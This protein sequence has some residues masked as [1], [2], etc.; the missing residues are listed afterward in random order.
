MKKQFL[1]HSILLISASC[2]LVYGLVQPPV[3]NPADG[4]AY[5]NFPLTITCPTPG[6]VIRYTLNGVEPTLYD[7]PITSGS[8]VVINRNWIVKAKA[9]LAQESSATTTG[10]FSITGDVSAGGGHTLALE[11]QGRVWA[12]GLQTNG[13]LG[14]NSVANA[15][16]TSPVASLYSAT[17]VVGDASMVAA[18]ASHSVFLK[19]GGTVWSC[20][21]NS[22]GALGNNSTTS[23]G[24]AV[25]VRKSTVATDFLTGM[26]AVAAGDGFSSALSSSGEVYTWGSKSSGRLGD[27]ATSGSR[28]YAGKVLQGPS[29]STP[30][31]GIAT[32]ANA[33]G[34]AMAISPATH[35]VWV[36]GNNSNGQLGQG[37]TSNLSRAMKMKLNAT[38]ELTDIVDVAGG[39]NHT[40]ILRWK[41]GDPALQGRVFCCGQQQYGRLGNNQ[42]ATA[43]VTYPVQV[44]K[45]GATPLD[46][47]VSIAAGSGHTLALDGNGNVWAWGYNLYGALGDNTTTSRGTASKVLNPTGTGPLTNI[48]RISASGSTTTGHS[49]AIAADGTVYA[50]GYNSNGQLGNGSA[51]TAA[52]RLPSPVVGGLDLLPNPPD[53]SVGVNVTQNPAPGAVTITATVSDVDGPDNVQSVEFYDQ[54]VLVATR[55]SVPWTVSLSGIPAG[56]H[57]VYAI[58]TDAQGYSGMSQPVAFGIEADNDHD[59]LSDAWEI[60][61]FGNIISQ[62]AASDADGDKV[63][64]AIEK[65][66]ATNPLAAADT[67]GDG[68]PDDW[69]KYHF[70]NITS[71]SGVGDVDGDKINSSA[72]WIK[73]TNP[74]RNLNSDNDGLPDDWE[75][76]WFGDLA[77]QSGNSEA[78]ADHVI[79]AQE[80]T[81]NTN[82][83][84]AADGDVDGLPDDWELYWFDDST[85][86]S[87]SS[88]A[89]GDLVSNRHEWL[90]GTNP[91]NAVDRD[92]D[93]LPDD[94]ERHWF[95]DITSNSGNSDVDEDSVSNL[96][97]FQAGT[98][99]APLLE[100][101]NANGVPDNQE[102]NDGDGMA[103]SWEQML[104]DSSGGL[105]EL[106][107]QNILPGDDFDNDGLANWIEYQWGF[108]AYQA[109]SDGDGYDD[110][111]A[112]AQ[113]L[114]L[115]LD[116]AGGGVAEDQSFEQSV[117]V[118]SGTLAWQTNGGIDGGALMFH[119]GADVVEIPFDVL[120]G[121]TALTVSLWFK[122]SNP[123]TSQT[124]LSSTSAARSPEFA[125]GIENGSSIRVHTGGGQSVAWSFGRSLVD[126]RWHHLVVTRDSALGRVAL[127]IDGLAF[128]FPQSL[129][130]GALDLEKISLGQRHQS[131]SSF[132][133]NQAFIGLL[134]EIRIFSGILDTKDV[135][136]LFL[137][138]DLDQDGLPDDYELFLFQN[139]ATLSGAN[140]DLDGDGLTNR[141]EYENGT[142]PNDYY[143]GQAPVISLFS[144]YGQTIHSG[145][146]TLQPLVFLVTKNSNPLSNAPVSLSQFPLLGGFETMDGDIFASSLI[147]KSDAQGKVA[148][149]FKAN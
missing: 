31:A 121:E 93:G 57:H 112:I 16:I 79:N 51:S 144:G 82:P 41:T 69:E 12:W 88:D 125:I 66:K 67:D 13:R 58:V 29:G 9:W 123:A 96:L 72:E 60:Q 54:G 44:V 3:L 33:S 89:D 17:T 97:E 110:Q 117:G 65:L 70:G 19:N 127:H 132:V 39:P 142:S 118:L 30:L 71:Q 4:E 108:S 124:L 75:I 11:A 22:T 59:G 46:G 26:V 98:S 99:P 141:K 90:R 136:R 100:D 106:S 45:S 135:A 91:R 92:R 81:Q 1:T 111:L 20:G 42:T 74:T 18:G 36:W 27:G 139:L 61:W 7:L 15:N 21:L 55:T 14:N 120:G 24:L 64:N 47:I 50:W 2:G 94:W 148:I 37:N 128:G 126:G 113:K 138:N 95:G 78:D 8:T 34:T 5:A 130:L 105:L 104:I 25:Q 114:H 56:N 10:N 107:P 115:R 129:T 146:R 134:D 76:F 84:I 48:I 83:T 116:E 109:D 35:N 122:S 6:A 149:H 131:V 28:L 86:Q 147:L 32:I 145:N 53:V 87:G 62:S 68:M 119:G 40:V 85:S 133:P 73:N 103:D 63:N 43:N 38:T 140:D 101:L 23:S 77:I 52:N 143:N 80:W 102:D 137:P 49:M